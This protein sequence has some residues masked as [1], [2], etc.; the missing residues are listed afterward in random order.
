MADASAAAGSSSS[1][2]Y[3]IRQVSVVLDGKKIMSRGRVSSSKNYSAFE[4]QQLLAIASSEKPVSQADWDSVAVIF[5]G[6]FQCN[7][8]GRD[9]RKKFMKM[10]TTKPKTGMNLMFN[11]FIFFILDRLN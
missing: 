4:T 9:L 2:P 8:R 6:F 10:A 7:R 5:N 11:F 1:T 3:P